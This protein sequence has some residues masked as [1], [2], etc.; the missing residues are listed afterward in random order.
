MARPE[1]KV[2]VPIGGRQQ[3]VI[4]TPPRSNTAA[5]T[6]GLSSPFTSAFSPV[7]LLSGA[8]ANRQA[9]ATAAIAAADSASNG[10]YASQPYQPY[11]PPS[12]SNGS[13]AETTGAAR[14]GEPNPEALKRVNRAGQALTGFKETVSALEAKAADLRVLMRDFE[15]S[16]AAHNSPPRSA[17]KQQTS[18]PRP[19]SA[20]RTVRSRS[21]P[22]DRRPLQ[23]RSKSA[24]AER[25]RSSGGSAS[26]KPAAPTDRSA[27]KPPTPDQKAKPPSQT[28]ATTNGRGSGGA[29]E[30][31]DG[32][33]R[34]VRRSRKSTAGGM[35]ISVGQR[36][37][38]LNQLSTAGRFPDPNSTARKAERATTD[39]NTR[40]EKPKSERKSDRKQ[41]P[42][43]FRSEQQRAA[44]KP[45]A[46]RP[47]S[48]RSATPQRTA[49]ANGSAATT[50][51]AERRRLAEATKRVAARQPP[52]PHP[53]WANSAFAEASDKES[54]FDY[55]RATARRLTAL[56]RSARELQELT[57]TINRLSLIRHR[58]SDAH[59]R[60]MRQQNA[61]LM[62][63]QTLG[64]SGS[65]HSVTATT[66]G[67]VMRRGE[68]S[69]GS[70]A[71]TGTATGGG[72]TP[73]SDD[74]TRSKSLSS[75]LEQY[76]RLVTAMNSI[77]EKTHSQM[78]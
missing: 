24:S 61:E 49:P 27:T 48:A 41:P 47:A 64:G 18:K 17:Q 30:S 51:E 65:R 66:I 59:T 60:Q 37:R 69:A 39:Q 44:P 53:E 63:A 52:P 73:L 71:A 38:L 46:K 9:L 21:Q 75:L 68:T 4:H 20:S 6:N 15:I 33:I 62:R 8:A 19:R 50:S 67:L 36:Q 56:D 55:E 23:Q 72:P 7:A 78:L 2:A 45:A 57:N 26:I 25:R 28:A 5:G 1:L 3:T 77:A 40:T 13:S 42:A 31:T 32:F 35:S 22:T 70:V 74:P 16:N 29:R 14:Y 43:T 58:L 12:Q 54:A 10:P 11:Q 34:P 76:D